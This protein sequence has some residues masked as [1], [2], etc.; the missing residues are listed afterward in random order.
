MYNRG[1]NDEHV[2]DFAERDR[3]LSS[4]I[5]NAFGKQLY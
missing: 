1:L 4:W 5:I 3:L 2:T